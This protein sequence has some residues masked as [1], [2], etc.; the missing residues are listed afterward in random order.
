MRSVQQ[1]WPAPAGSSALLLCGCCKIRRGPSLSHR[2]HTHIEQAGSCQANLP[3]AVAWTGAPLA[4]AGDAGALLGPQAGS[5]PRPAALHGQGQGQGLERGAQ[6]AGTQLLCRL[7]C[8]GCAAA[9]SAALQ[10]TWTD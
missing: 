7:S 2:A 1:H 3:A 5:V 9:G 8:W 4:V 10:Q 6:A